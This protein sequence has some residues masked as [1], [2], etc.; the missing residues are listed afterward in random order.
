MIHDHEEYPHEITFQIGKN[1]PDGGGGYKVEG[2]TDVF[3][4]EAFV[5]P[6]SSKEFYRARQ[7]QTPIDYNV[8]FPYKEDVKPSMRIKY[9]D[10]Y[11]A[12]KS[13]PIDLG[14]WGEKLM[15]KCVSI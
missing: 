7:A 9:G 11:L 4:T 2:W 8:L 15:L 6:V 14:G 3:T 5:N 12:L 13:K 10:Q 1:V